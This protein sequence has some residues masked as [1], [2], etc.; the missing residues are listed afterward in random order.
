MKERF[1]PLF[2]KANNFASPELTKQPQNTYSGQER[3]EFIMPDGTGS[4][5]FKTP[6]PPGPEIKSESHLGEAPPIEEIPIPHPSSDLSER[7]HES[8]RGLL[9]DIRDQLGEEVGGQFQNRVLHKEAG[10][11]IN[12]YFGELSPLPEVTFRESDPDEPEQLRKNREFAEDQVR[13][14]IEKYNQIAVQDQNGFFGDLSQVQQAVAEL[15]SYRNGLNSVA[16]LDARQEVSNRIEEMISAVVRKREEEERVLRESMTDREFQQKMH[17]FYGDRELTVEEV[18][19]LIMNPTFSEKGNKGSVPTGQPEGQSPEAVHQNTERDLERL[20]NRIF[21]RVDSQPRLEFNEAMGQAGQKEWSD[22]LRWLNEGV[23]PKENKYIQFDYVKQELEKGGEV[24][25]SH[26]V[27]AKIRERVDILKKRKAEYVNLYNTRVMLHNANMAVLRNTGIEQLNNYVSSFQTGTADMVFRKRGVQEAYR[28]YTQALLKIRSRYGGYIPETAM[29]SDPNNIFA[30]G[31]GEV[32]KLARQMFDQAMNAQV[33][34]D[35]KTGEVVAMEE[36]EISSAFEYAR[37]LGIMLG[38]TTEIAATSTIPPENPFVGMFGQAI[39]EKVQV[40]RTIHKYDIGGKGNSVLGMQLDRKGRWTR[41]EIID[42]KHD[43]GDKTFAIMNGILEEEDKSDRLIEMLNVFGMGGV[44]SVS[45]W[46]AGDGY[47]GG[48]LSQLAK[49][50]MDWVGSGLLIEKNRG[51]L[52]SSDV[53]ARKEA[54]MIISGQID[55]MKNIQPLVLYNNDRETQAKVLES[56]FGDEFR[57]LDG[58]LSGDDRKYVDDHFRKYRTKFDYNGTKIDGWDEGF[59]QVLKATEKYKSSPSVKES[60]SISDK[61]G[62]FRYQVDNL[63]DR[64]TDIS[65]KA[66]ILQEAALNERVEDW[67]E[68]FISKKNKVKKTYKSDGSWEEQKYDFEGVSRSRKGEA[69]Y[70]KSKD[71]DEAL[72]FAE[73]VRG[74]FN[75]ERYMN[76]L[77]D[78][79]YK[80]PFVLDVTGLDNRQIFWSKGGDKAISRRWGDM[81]HIE[82]GTQAVM[83]FIT[84]LK[85]Y[86]SP[87]AVAGGLQ[88]IYDEVKGYD[89][90]V[91]RDLTKKLGEAAIKFYSKDWYYRSPGGIGAMLGLTKGAVQ[92]VSASQALLGTKAMAWD[93]IDASNLTQIMRAHGTWS[94]DVQKELQ[95]KTIAKRNKVI[96]AYLRFGIPVVIL[97]AMLWLN[98]EETEDSH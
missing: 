9:N 13:K 62:N 66:A 79:G 48:A 85:T 15:A 12:S 30:E 96:A 68:L 50:D 18:K 21:D 17:S 26:S 52:S 31:G 90:D 58:M 54:E 87:E 86:D 37:G 45:T 78:K 23:S 88:K 64:I 40:F 32:D 84:G 44:V 74:S 11:P 36:D 49:K 61:N 92:G 39:I 63:V 10:E 47:V 81:M 6:S 1:E 72:Q 53:G 95:G 2:Q 7:A 65:Q 29:L 34:R 94:P 33:I 83:D 75:T 27:N 8:D 20:F 70:D 42:F 57:R 46:R 67:K 73:L 89:A 16:N 91:A 71:Y 41:D 97:G 43:Q 76:L 19:D 5:D 59:L 98:K 77:K 28:F 22:F 60:D 56:M 24:V 3:G 25:D 93:E 51:N 69:D 35:P 82:G 55:R 80:Q 14:L 4:P 38:T